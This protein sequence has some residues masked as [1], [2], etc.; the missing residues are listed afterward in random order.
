MQ[1]RIIVFYLLLVLFIPPI[2]AKQKIVPRTKIPIIFVDNINGSQP[3]R[4]G[5][6]VIFRV[7]ENIYQDN[8]LIFKQGCKGY[9][10]VN[11][12][13]HK[14]AVLPKAGKISLGKGYVKSVDGQIIS[15]YPTNGKR[16]I[17]GRSIAKNPVFWG[18]LVAWPL[19]LVPK[20]RNAGIKPGMRSEVFTQ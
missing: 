13:E 8:T 4:K 18:S 5:D 9:L 12:I 15:V 17:K 14:G 6:V 19:K 2:Q 10:E 20:A 1:Q 16:H 11:S 3:Q 7:A